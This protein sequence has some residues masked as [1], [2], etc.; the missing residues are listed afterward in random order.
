[1]LDEVFS[2]TNL[3]VFP[4]IS[5]PGV[6]LTSKIEGVPLIGR[7]CLKEGGAYFKE[8]GTTHMKFQNL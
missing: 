8:R 7:W 5:D 6:Y 1:M 4:L 2:R 3:T